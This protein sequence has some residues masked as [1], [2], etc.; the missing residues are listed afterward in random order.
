MAGIS[1]IF[2]THFTTKMCQVRLQ[3]E[4]E[5]KLGTATKDENLV[6]AEATLKKHGKPRAKSLGDARNC[7]LDTSGSGQKRVAGE[8]ECGGRPELG[9]KIEALEPVEANFDPTEIIDNS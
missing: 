6:P 5:V 2:T 4:V 9:H 7:D 8:S 1:S 3:T